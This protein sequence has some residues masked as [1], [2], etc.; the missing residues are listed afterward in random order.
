IAIFDYL[1]LAITIVTGVLALALVL[2]M[3]LQWAQVNPFGWFALN[4]RKV[5]EPVMRP[6]RYGFDN[7]MLR[8]DMLPIV[9]AAL[10]LLNGLFAAW[11]VGQVSFVLRQFY[12][13]PA[14]T[15]GLVLSAVLWFAVVAYMAML[16]GRFLLPMLGFGYS[17]RFLR[18]A[19]Q[20][21]EPVLKPLRRYLVIGA[22]DFSPVVVIFLV[23]MIGSW[24]CAWLARL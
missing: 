13:A 16:F 17:S 22:F 8:F 24:L 6:F 14:I 11:I 21:T 2:R 15:I 5:T 9:A 10:V 7:Q 23:Q 19:F 4:L 18:V 20:L 12:R 3:V 1:A